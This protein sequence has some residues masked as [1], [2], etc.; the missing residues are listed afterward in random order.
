MCKICC[1]FI[2]YTGGG[3]L[4]EAHLPRCMYDLLFGAY[5]TNMMDASGTVFEKSQIQD[6][7]L[8][9]IY[10]RANLS[11]LIGVAREVDVELAIDILR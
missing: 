6:L 4:I 3:Q 11:L 1:G 10:Q 5:Q 9:E 7:S 8:L 2:E